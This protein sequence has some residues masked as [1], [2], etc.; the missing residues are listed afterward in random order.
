M[1]KEE[2]A[3]LLKPETSL[4]QQL[5]D[6]PEF[7]D[8]LSWGIP[9]YGHPEGEVYKHVVEVLYNIDSIPALQPLDRTRLRLAAF[10]HDTFKKH[11]HRGRPR[12]WTRH[13]SCLA[14]QFMECYTQDIV[15]LDLIE[16]HDEAYYAWQ[17][18]NNQNPEEG[19]RRLQLILDKLGDHLQL[20]YLF[21]KC[22]T[23]T[24][25][26]NPAPVKWFE[27]HFSDR[28]EVVHLI[29]V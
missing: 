16:Y 19:D 13:H 14:R 20:F 11:E 6:S 25:D 8:G 12:D 1:H 15:L 3:A 5:L 27:R 26:K 18:F 9:R 22:D 4:E 28:I 17:S 29:R 24:G 2:I 21:F 23:Y 10:S 7:L